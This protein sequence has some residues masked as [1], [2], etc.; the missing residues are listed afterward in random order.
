MEYWTRWLNTLTQHSALIIWLYGNSR[1]ITFALNLYLFLKRVLILLNVY[2]ILFTPCGIIIYFKCSLVHFSFT[3]IDLPKPKSFLRTHCDWHKQFTV[4][5]GYFILTDQFLY[6]HRNRV[7][8][9]PFL[10]FL[11]DW[12]VSFLCYK[13]PK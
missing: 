4:A 1:A 7:P 9:L 2:Q 13:P 5:S 11:C 12:C 3:C 10:Q 6:H 8:F